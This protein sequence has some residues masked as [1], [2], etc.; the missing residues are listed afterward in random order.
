MKKISS[1]IVALLMVICL[2]SC[3]AKELKSYIDL[4]SLIELKT[5]DAY[6]LLHEYNVNDLKDIW[7]SPKSDI[8]N[9]CIWDTN[10]KRIIVVYDSYGKITEVAFENINKTNEDEETKEGINNDSSLI[11]EYDDSNEGINNESPLFQENIN[12]NEEICDGLPLA[13]ANFLNLELI[14]IEDLTVTNQ[15]STDTAL[16]EFYKDD[17]YTYYFP[18]IKSEYI[19]CEFSNGDKMLFKQALLNG[20]VKVTDLD[21]YGIQYWLVDKDGNYINS[22]DN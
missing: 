16:E 22:L 18:S 7:G 20:V 8:N 6:K 19:I 15:L 1:L 2:I 4:S 10:D 17:Q 13:P 5:D 3:N 11:H 9:A 14:N 21:N 12:P